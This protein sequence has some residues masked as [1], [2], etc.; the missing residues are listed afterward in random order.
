MASTLSCKR[1]VRQVIFVYCLRTCRGSRAEYLVLSGLR[2][3]IW[4]FHEALQG[5]MPVQKFEPTR[6]SLKYGILCT[7]IKTINTI[8]Q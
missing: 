1:L 8:H 7:L 4:F 3:G 5:T 2:Q 6:D